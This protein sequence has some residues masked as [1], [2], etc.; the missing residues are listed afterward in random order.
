MADAKITALTNLATPAGAD[1]F[2]IVDD[3][4]GTPTTKKATLSAVEA[5][6]SHTN[7]TNI[8]TN[9]HA[10]IDSHLAST[11]NPHSVTL[12]QVGGTT[13]HTALS[14]IGTNTH[15]AIDT[16]IA[17]SAIHF[18]SAALWTAINDH[19]ASTAIHFTD[20]NLVK[21]TGDQT[22]AGS[23]TFSSQALVTNDQVTSMAAYI[24]NLVFGFSATPPTAS[25]VAQGTL[26]I[27]YTP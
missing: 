3:V 6:L 7:I 1:L 12:A 19:T 21:L 18:T 15:A 20:A 14:N 25:T 9:S 27:Q 8:G 26:Y 13:D 4:A 16:H 17:S 11:A 24:G 10:T 5:V 22:I 2:V 23:K